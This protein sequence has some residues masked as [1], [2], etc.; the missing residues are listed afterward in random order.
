MKILSSLL[1]VIGFGLF[2]FNVSDFY[3]T[4]K[5]RTRG[6]DDYFLGYNLSKRLQITFSVMM[7]SSGILLRKKS[8]KK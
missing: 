4:H 6:S 8:N 1:I 3:N 2:S 7:V 5:Y